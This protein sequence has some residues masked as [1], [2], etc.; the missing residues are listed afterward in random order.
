MSAFDVVIG[1]ETE[2]E[3]LMQICDTVRNPE[4]YRRL[5]VKMPRGLLL[6]GEPGVGKTLMATA[7]MKETG[8]KSFVCRKTRAGTDFLRDIAEIFAAA[9]EAA[10]SVL[11]LDDLDKFSEDAE[12]RNPEEYVA[13]QSGMDSVADRDVFVVAT[14]NRVYDLPDSL[15]RHGRFDRVMEIGFPSRTEAVKIITHYLG[16]KKVAGDVNPESV[17]RIMD[18]NSC[19][20]LE[21]VLNDAGIYA[22]YENRTEIGTEDIVR[23]V[24]RNIFET[25]ESVS[26]MSPALRE[27]VAF[28]EAGHAVVSLSFDADSVGLV[29]VRPCRHGRNGVVQMLKNEDY[30]SSYRQMRARCVA[31]LAGRAAVEIRFGH[32]DPGATSDLD[33]VCRVAERFVAEY[34]LRGFQNLSI[35]RDS[36]PSGS[37]NRRISTAARAEIEDMYGEAKEILGKN[38]EAVERLAAALMRKDTLIY[39]EIA[40]VT[41]GT[42]KPADSRNG[43]IR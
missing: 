19:A 1:Y 30:W 36:F 33:R 8:R 15:R 13:V 38:W 22:G 27:E 6:H 17:A 28:H 43:E 37:R 32:V 42:L 25:E 7:F 34:G 41:A 24:L 35:G 10:P 5:G 4:K 14:A 39:E 20:A 31:I 2:K 29:S 18:G 12:S 21:G 9:V 11:L 23:A 40:E 26:D 3:E 16:D